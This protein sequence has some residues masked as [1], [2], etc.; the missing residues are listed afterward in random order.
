[1]VFIQHQDFV[2]KVSF[3]KRTFWSKSIN[4]MLLNFLCK[5]DFITCYCYIKEL[6]SFYRAQRIRMF[7]ILKQAFVNFLLSQIIYLL[8][9]NF[10]NNTHI[11]NANITRWHTIFPHMWS[12]AEWKGIKRKFL[13]TSTMISSTSK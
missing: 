1:M 4:K 2:I 7:W 6:Q 3:P 10:S 9:L 5:L 13:P 11:N 12:P 8:N